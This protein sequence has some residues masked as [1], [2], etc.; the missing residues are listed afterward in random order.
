MVVV[1]EVRQPSPSLPAQ[2]AWVHDDSAEGKCG[3]TRV[4]QISGGRCVLHSTRTRA[5]RRLI[6]FRCAVPPAAG[7]TFDL[8]EPPQD[9]LPARARSQGG[10]ALGGF[11]DSLGLSIADHSLVRGVD[12]LVDKVVDHS[13]VRKVGALRIFREPA[14]HAPGAAVKLFGCW[15]MEWMGLRTHSNDDAQFMATSQ[16][17]LS[18]SCGV[19][20]WMLLTPPMLYLNMW[21]RSS[22]SSPSPSPSPDGHSPSPSPTIDIDHEE[23]KKLA[24]KLA[25]GMDMEDIL[26]YGKDQIGV[27]ML[28]VLA[29]FMLLVVPAIFV[30]LCCCPCFTMPCIGCCAAKDK[31]PGACHSLNYLVTR[32]T[33]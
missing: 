24:K 15:S 17:A 20:L 11:S 26:E 9:P 13:L 22:S 18:G 31:S 28:S 29:T 14:P 33:R 12:G 3:A 25:K 2:L 5:C 23:A 30:L 6:F 32:P 16:W 21:A 8:D 27:E 1:N 4:V 7:L 19:A 10:Q